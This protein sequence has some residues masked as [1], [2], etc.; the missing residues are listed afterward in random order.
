MKS[1]AIK[2]F[3]ALS[4][5][6]FWLFPLLSIIPN[7]FSSV[8]IIEKVVIYAI[9]LVSTTIIILLVWLSFFGWRKNNLMKKL[10]P[11][12]ECNKCADI[13]CCLKVVRPGVNFKEDVFMLE[14][15]KF[16]DEFELATLE[17]KLP[18]KEVWIISP[19]LSYECEDSFFTEV[20]KRNL[21]QGVKYKF[22]SQ[23]SPDSR[24][25]SKK[26]YS[27]YTNKINQLLYKNRLVFY[28]SDASEFNIVLSLYS[29]VVY[30]PSPKTTKHKRHVFICVGENGNDV[31][32]VYKE[33]DNNH[34]INLTLDTIH[35]IMNTTTPVKQGKRRR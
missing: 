13:L 3:K 24:E 23:D 34:Q 18:L 12:S 29:I 14:S 2:T 22:F 20:V 26:V 4:Y 8:S 30:N 27:K 6:I 16:I 28:L 32:S 25:N 5:L 10:L 19:D 33:I 9:M 17:G 21:K 11:S 35:S 1:I 7:M 15:S 31:H